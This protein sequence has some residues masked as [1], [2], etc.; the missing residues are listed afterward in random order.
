M[1]DSVKVELPSVLESDR[2]RF[3]KVLLLKADKELLR[4]R[5]LRA[6]G[7]TALL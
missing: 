6:V 7:S 2:A 3:S 5:A 1:G 4:E